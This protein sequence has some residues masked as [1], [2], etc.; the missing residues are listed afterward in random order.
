MVKAIS[1]LAWAHTVMEV[2][3]QQQREAE[4]AQEEAGGA[5]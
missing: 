5:A 4:E 1:E 3:G 2:P